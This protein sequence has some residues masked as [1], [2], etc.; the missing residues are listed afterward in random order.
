MLLV[1]NVLQINNILQHR[2]LSLYIN[3]DY[4]HFETCHA[5]YQYY[6]AKCI[7]PI[8]ISTATATGESCGCSYYCGYTTN[9]IPISW[10]YCGFYP[11]THGNIADIVPLPW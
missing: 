8:C 7:I 2:M 5:M 10:Y 1:T 6:L 11:H 3:T 4:P 9:S